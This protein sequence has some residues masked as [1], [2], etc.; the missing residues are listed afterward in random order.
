MPY[1]AVIDPPAVRAL[2]RKVWGAVDKHL[3]W[4]FNP[5]LTQ[6]LPSRSETAAR[7]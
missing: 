2:H 6:W 5:Q 7:R 4:A 3:L 1:P